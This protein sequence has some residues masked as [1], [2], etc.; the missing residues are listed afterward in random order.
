MCVTEPDAPVH[1]RFSMIIVPT[2]TKW[3]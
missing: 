2:D 1:E 3:L